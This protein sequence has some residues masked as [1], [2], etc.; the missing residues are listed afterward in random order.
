MEKFVFSFER[1]SLESNMTWYSFAGK[2]TF[3]ALLNSD[4]DLDTFT[5]NFHSG[6]E[7]V[8]KNI[9][10]SVVF[11]GFIRL[12][13]LKIGKIRKRSVRLYYPTPV[14]TGWHNHM[15]PFTIL[16]IT[17]LHS[18]MLQ[19]HCKVKRSGFVLKVLSIIFWKVSFQTMQGV[20]LKHNPQK[21]SFKTSLSKSLLLNLKLCVLP[22]ME[23][24]FI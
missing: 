24:T 18:G 11:R 13:T 15:L 3:S 21:V 10:F 8:L 4:I 22:N 6:M 23:S 19:K 17:T 14:V 12:K 7:F 9:W 2:R 16:C 1:P 5:D 20:L